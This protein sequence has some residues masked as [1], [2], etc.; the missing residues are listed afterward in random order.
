LAEIS[1]STPP[2]QRL[3]RNQIGRQ[4]LARRDLKLNISICTSTRFD[5]HILHR[6]QAGFQK[7][8]LRD[9]WCNGSAISR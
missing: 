6:K 1:F 2:D 3:Y 4:R 5:T 7:H 9:A 8:L